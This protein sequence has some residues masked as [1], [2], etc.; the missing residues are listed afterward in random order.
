M[1]LL[2][3][4]EKSIVAHVPGQISVPK[5]Q[6]LNYHIYRNH[7]QEGQA[8][9][10]ISA[11]ITYPIKTT[12]WS[13]GCYVVREKEAREHS[14]LCMVKKRKEEQ[15]IKFVYLTA[16]FFITYTL[17]ASLASKIF[18]GHFCAAFISQKSFL[19]WGSYCMIKMLWSWDAPFAQNRTKSLS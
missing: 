9:K 17:I 14:A 2:P 11:M 6:N 5:T 3:P 8:A 4:S 13:A 10:L 18:W 12:L 19:L 15:Y 1:R 7:M 16:V